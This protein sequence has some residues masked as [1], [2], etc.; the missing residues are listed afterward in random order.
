MKTINL[1][2]IICSITFQ[3]YSQ[4]SLSYHVSSFLKTFST[5]E[6]L[7]PIIGIDSIDNKIKKT[8]EDNWTFTKLRFVPINELDEF[9]NAPNVSI[10]NLLTIIWY[11][12][13]S[14]VNSG[15]GNTSLCFYIPANIQDTRMSNIIA[16]IPIQCTFPF[17]DGFCTECK[18]EQINYKI[19]ILL[20]Q[21][22][23]VVNF[24]SSETYEM[25]VVHDRLKQYTKKYNKKII[26]DNKICLSASFPKIIPFLCHNRY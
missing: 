15:R 8:L 23:E 6:T 14:D 12:S 20:M 19:D 16:S 18:F 25:A 22:I 24:A 4:Y 7:V 9:D 13:G 3:G 17:L 2:I 21:L 10:I 5:T 1:I 26:R 11:V